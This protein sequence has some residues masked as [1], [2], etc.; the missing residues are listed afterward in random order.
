M[1]SQVFAEQELALA[2]DKSANDVGGGA[3]IEYLVYRSPTSGGFDMSVGKE[4]V[5]IPADGSATYFFTI[6]LPDGFSFVVVTAVGP[7]GESEPSNEVRYFFG[8]GTSRK[9]DPDLA[10]PIGVTVPE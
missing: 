8:E 6:I 2:F 7:L 3:V 4:V 1:A 10:P 5:T 9:A